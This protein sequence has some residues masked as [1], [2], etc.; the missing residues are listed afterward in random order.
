MCDAEQ[1]KNIFLLVTNYDISNWFTLLF[2]IIMWPLVLFL[3]NRKKVQ[4]IP[5]LEVST[6]IGILDI[7]GSAY[8][9]IWL[10]FSN[11]TGSTVYLSN[12]RLLKCTKL[13]NV[14]LASTRDLSA[15]AYELNF[16][17]GGNLNQRQII[18]DTNGQVETAIALDSNP[19]KEILTFKPSLWRRIFRHPKY[20]CLEYTAMVGKER[21]HVSTIY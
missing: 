11:Q 8:P 4:S 18:L 5:S 19:N 3:W 9:A 13:L 1:L 10:K 12:A 20:F 7:G 14:A 6:P 21:Y 17:V 2:T 16:S 15:A